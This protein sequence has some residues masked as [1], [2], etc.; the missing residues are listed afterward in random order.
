MFDTNAELQAWLTD[1]NKAKLKV[2]DILYIKE[3]DYPDYWWDGTSTQYLE[4]QKV[5]LTNY[6]TKSDHDF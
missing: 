1:E 3:T 6:R 4:T 5:D 2:G